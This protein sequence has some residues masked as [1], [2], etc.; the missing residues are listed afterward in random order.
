M[1]ILR[2]YRNFVE[3]KGLRCSMAG[4]RSLDVNQ[5]PGVLPRGYWLL[6]LKTLTLGLSE[7]HGNWWSTATGGPH[8]FESSGLPMRPLIRP[9]ARNVPM[10]IP[11]RM[12]T[13]IEVWHMS[14]HS[15]TVASILRLMRLKRRR[16]RFVNESGRNFEEKER[17]FRMREAF[18]SSN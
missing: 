15:S 12:D 7:Q 9:A 14:G 18:W 6:V 4:L 16:D 8:C 1:N 13:L 5:R 11:G 17:T 3:G 2:C 10:P